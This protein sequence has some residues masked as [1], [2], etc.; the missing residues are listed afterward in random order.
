MP[1]RTRK[2]ASSGLL[3]D[4]YRPAM[5]TSAK[6]WELEN[7]RLRL[8]HKLI[9]QPP[10]TTAAHQPVLTLVKHVLLK[11]GGTSANPGIDIIKEIFRRQKQT[12]REVRRLGPLEHPGRG[13]RAARSVHR[14]G[15][16]EKLWPCMEA[17][18][19]AHRCV[20]TS[21]SYQWGLLAFGSAPN[22]HSNGVHA[23]DSLILGALAKGRSASRR[24]APLVMKFQFARGC[25][26]F[27]ST[28]LHCR[29]SPQPG[30]W[31]QWPCF[32]SAAPLERRAGSDFEQLLDFCVT[33]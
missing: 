1:G 22:I 19:G 17:S 15:N 32:V 12:G 21:S 26:I 31:S 24:L 27:H 11:A 20:G 23:M 6:T 29:T 30:R 33:V 14:G 3:P 7:A 16:G 2:R 5:S 8:L 10:R 28:T 4:H 13:C 18:R 9:P 25:S